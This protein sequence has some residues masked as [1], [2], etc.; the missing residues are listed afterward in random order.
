MTIADKLEAALPAN[1]ADTGPVTLPAH[2][3][4]SAVSE[5]KAAW[6]AYDNLTARVDGMFDANIEAIDRM[7][8][9]KPYKL[10]AITAVV[11]FVAGAVVL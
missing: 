9:A 6:A 4:R 5:L 1:D 11:A 3:V 8:E 10:I 7:G 2:V